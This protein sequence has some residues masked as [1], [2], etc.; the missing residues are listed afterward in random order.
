[1]TSARHHLL[2]MLL[3]A[4]C[5]LACTTTPVGVRRVA[6]RV[7]HH[8]LT[9]NVLTTGRPSSSSTQV[10]DRFDLA[11]EYRRAPELALLGL[12]EAAIAK[13]SSDPGD[14]L[15]AL[16]E[17]EFHRAEQLSRA[18]ARPH[19]LAAAL[20]ANGFM[21]RAAHSAELTALDPRFRLAA[22]LYNRGLTSGLATEDGEHVDLTSRALPL[23]F[24]ELALTADE[25]SFL[26]GGYRMIDFVP[27]A[28]LE[29][30][31]LR[32]RYRR[33]GLGAPLAASLEPAELADPPRGFGHLSRGIHVPATAVVFFPSALL[34]S[35]IVD[36]KLEIYTL[37][38]ATSVRI[39]TQNVAL[40][41]EPTAALAFSLADSRPWDSERAGFLS[42]DFGKEH[43]GLRMLA[44]YDP[45]RIPVVLVHGTASSP[46]R[47]AEMLNSLQADEEVLKRY[48]FW[49]FQ[50]NTGSPIQ[51][52]A[53]LLRQSLLDLV[54][55]LDPEKDDVNLQRTVLIGH[56]QGGLLAHLCVVESGDA[57]W[58]AISQ[59]PIDSLDLEP[60]TRA[61]IE[62]TLF[63]HPL[64]FVERVIFIATPHRGSFLADRW[65][66]RVASGFVT[67]PREF[68]EAA[69]ELFL[70]NDDRVLLRS[71]DDLPSS[72]DNMTS[73]SR[74]LLTLVELPMPPK[75]EAHSII[76]VLPGQDIETGNDGVVTVESARIDGVVS[77]LIVRSGHS[78]QTTPPTIGEVRR[79]L[80]SAPREPIRTTSSGSASAHESAPSN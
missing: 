18:A 39:G 78:T 28:E 74:F 46:G 31:G 60:E 30:R 56:S 57:F 26:W 59:A 72:L 24:G 42:G 58:Q 25:E 69:G 68:S 19:F 70:Q 45:E 67:L 63:V 76:A 44:P 5:G 35:P 4:G 27:V 79:I 38:D 15:F 17:L 3:A 21:S 43:R 55:V 11:E 40:E 12:R 20:Y 14:L 8:A 9:A 61:L 10:L 48:Q 54:A 23:P 6:P 41:Y 75:V 77:E 53:G 62:R 64:P 1:M 52:S 80:R 2:A 36:A 13:A 32:N 73:D 37:D 49:I 66:A 47:W 50:Y 71:L 22:D 29:V 33:P 65:L 7:V 16:A 51:F 34:E